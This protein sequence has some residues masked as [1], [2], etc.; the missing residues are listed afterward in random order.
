MSPLGV[1]RLY[2]DFVDT[3]VI[4]ECDVRYAPRI[5]ALGMRVLVTDTLMTS[6][7]KSKR[8]ATAVLKELQS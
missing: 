3:F 8:L 1:A 6:P 2:T 4:D 5:A 7:A